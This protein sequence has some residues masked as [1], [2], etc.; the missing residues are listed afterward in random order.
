MWPEKT[1]PRRKSVRGLGSLYD[2]CAH[3][4]TGRRMNAVVVVIVAWAAI[5]F[6][7]RLR[8]CE[9]MMVCQPCYLG[10]FSGFNVAC[11]LMAKRT[12]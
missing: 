9:K 10:S 8:I 4:M 2:R 5:R 11:R 6:S 12:T 1:R 3:I 7:M